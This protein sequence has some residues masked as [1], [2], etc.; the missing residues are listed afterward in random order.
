MLNP[1][2]LIAVILASF[3]GVVGGSVSGFFLLML[4]KKLAMTWKKHTGEYLPR[5]I[6]KRGV[7]VATGPFLL[8]LFSI[9]RIFYAS[10]TGSDYPQ[11]VLLMFY[12]ASGIYFLFMSA[13]IFTMFEQLYKLSDIR[14]KKQNDFFGV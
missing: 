9:V 14:L 12:S 2:T 5:K 13:F 10:Q 4:L 7:L 3:F 1:E 6:V 11:M 8:A